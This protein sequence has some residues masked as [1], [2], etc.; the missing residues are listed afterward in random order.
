MYVVGE[1]HVSS[2]EKWLSIGDVLG[3]PAVHSLLIT[4]GPGASWSQGGVWPAFA[5][6]VCRLQ[7]YTSLAS[8]VCCLV[9]KVYL[10]ACAGFLVGGGGACPLVGRAISKGVFR[11]NCG[12]EK[13]L[14]SMSADLWSYV[15]T[16]LAVWP[17]VSQH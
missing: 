6:S 4:Q 3:V 11:D 2:L 12:L 14:G 1:L 17:E 9:G 5:D 16:P 13:S 8:G 10:E 15:P 7:D